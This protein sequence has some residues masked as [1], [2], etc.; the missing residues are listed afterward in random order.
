MRDRASRHR[1]E[2]M[3]GA[4][5]PMRKLCV[6][7]A[8]LFVTATAGPPTVAQRELSIAQI[9]GTKNLSE[10]VGETVSTSGIVTGRIRSGFFVQTP[11]ARADGDPLTSEGI[12]VFT[13]SEPPAEAAIG[14]EVSVTGKVEEY[15]NRNENYGLTITEISHVVGRDKIRV[16]SSENPLPKP[17]S[18]T[19]SDFSA[20]RVD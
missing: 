3:V 18:L 4:A 5:I 16:I 19:L 13:N 12:Y 11:D 17:I 9:Q 2:H 15:R 6:L 1:R 14:N 8:F 20:N 10:Y 7:F